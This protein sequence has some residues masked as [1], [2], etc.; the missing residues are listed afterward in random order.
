MNPSEHE[1]EELILKES[2]VSA[3][4]LR[5]GML[6]VGIKGDP[7]LRETAVMRP[8]YTNI[9]DDVFG[10]I[11]PRLT[12]LLLNHGT[13]RL[14]IGFSSAEIRT[15]SIF[16]PLREETH[17]AE[18]FM[19]Q[20]YIER[21][22]PLLPF[23]DKVQAMREL[24]E[25]LMRSPWFGRLPA[26]WRSIFQKRHESWQPMQPDQIRSIMATLKVLRD[27]PEYYLRST[28]LCIVQ[29]LVRLQFNCDGTQLVRAENY[30]RFLEENFPSQDA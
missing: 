12:D 23:D 9:M 1:M 26:F 24:Y 22:F 21:H 5:P 25:A 11:A 13:Y 30:L 7:S 4:G 8:K 18:K 17:A 14:Y 10:Q 19:D 2:I 15:A 20:D 27:M 28:S 29:D 16:D 3:A 6:Q